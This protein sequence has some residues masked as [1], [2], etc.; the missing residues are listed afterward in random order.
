MAKGYSHL[1]ANSRFM[2]EKMLLKG[3]KIVEIADTVGCSR[4]TI[5]NEL[6]ES[7]ICSSFRGLLERGGTVC[8]GKSTSKVQGKS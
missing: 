2:I 5:Y 6:K 3:F 8:S 7:Y 4:A 1:T